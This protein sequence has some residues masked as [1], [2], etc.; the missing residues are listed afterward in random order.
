MTR[1]TRAA[2]GARKRRRWGDRHHSETTPNLTP[3]IDI[4][5]QLLIFFVVTAAFLQNEKALSTPLPTDRGQEPPIEV[6]IPLASIELFL[7]RS[8]H[9]SEKHLPSTRLGSVSDAPDDERDRRHAG[10][11]PLKRRRAKM[12]SGIGILKA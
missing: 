5:F 6:S 4:V 7:A 12:H 11:T 10:P 1:P 2:S 3:L 9:R 8:S